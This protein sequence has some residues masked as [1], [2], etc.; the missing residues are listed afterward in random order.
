MPASTHPVLL[1]AP[2]YAPGGGCALHRYLD[3]DFVPRFRQ[4][5]DAG[6]LADPAAADWQQTDRFSRHDDALVLRL[7]LHRTFYLIACEAV[8]ERPGRPALDPARIV[9]AGFVIRRVGGGA[10]RLWRIDD[11]SPAGWPPLAQDSPGGAAAPDRDPDL[12]RRLHQRRLK[13]ERLRNPGSRARPRPAPAPAAY[14]G[15]ETH[16]LQP[17]AVTGPDGR[18][19]TVLFGF[20]PLGGQYHPPG[21]ALDNAAG[22]A[23]IAAD[24]GTLPDPLNRTG[25][26]ARH[27]HTSQA[28]LVQA[29]RPNA[30]FVAVLRL[31]VQ[32]YHL[33]EAP[34]RDDDNLD[35]AAWA[36]AQRFSAG[37]S[38]L[39]YLS[40]HAAVQSSGQPNAL[41]RWLAERDRAGDTAD[42]PL[43]ARPRGGGALDASLTITA[44]DAEELRE[45]LGG[46]VLA[47]AERL[48]SEVPVPKFQ[49]GPDD[50]FQVLPFLR[51]R[52]DDGCERV[53]WGNAVRSTRFRVAAPFDPDASRPTLVQ[54]PSLDDLRRGMAKGAAMLIPPDTQNLINALK[55]NKG[56]S[57]DVIGEPGGPGLG[58]Q[59]ICSFSLPVITLVAMILLMIMIALLNILFFWLPWVR[60]CLPFPKRT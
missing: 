15:E 34:A 52:D 39:D 41:V 7:P 11:G 36:A 22:N 44:D 27:W 29:G 19:R 47:I 23:L 8:C 54:M 26:L 53:T 40:A 60:I 50:L 21:K 4:A 10:E 2:H 48:G 35:L 13:L 43:P 56:A 20:L 38:L 14:T 49:Q 59:W 16:P 5:L 18:P 12:K 30:I 1:T 55:L 37:F 25:S 45:A 24:R 51:T 42:T 32:R 31:L 17:L 9:S 33:G 58:I 28:R 6:T 3:T 57:E 46:R